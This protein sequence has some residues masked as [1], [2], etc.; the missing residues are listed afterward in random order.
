MEITIESP[1]FTISTPLNDYVINKVSKLEHLDERLI[2]SDV[3]L[4]LDKSSTDDN[5]IC[6]I[7]I[8]AP[9]KTIFASRRSLTFEDAITQTVHAL[10][11]QLRK[12]KS[13]WEITN[14]EIHIEDIAPEGQGE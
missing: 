6:E 13:K 12:R 7:K 2:R 9:R 1:H 8:T 4:K 14:E 3:Y 10:E 5:K 11:K